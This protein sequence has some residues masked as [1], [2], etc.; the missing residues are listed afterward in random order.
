MARRLYP[1][2]GKVG[3]LVILGAAIVTS[4]VFAVNF[5]VA[6]S[7]IALG[8]AFRAG[9]RGAAFAFGHA[10]ASL[11]R[12]FA[13]RAL[14][15]EDEIAEPEAGPVIHAPKPARTEKR[16]VQPAPVEEAPRDSEDELLGRVIGDRAAHPANGHAETS[17][18]IDDL[19]RIL[20]SIELN[21]DDYREARDSAPNTPEPRISERADAKRQPAT[22]GQ[23]DFLRGTGPYIPPP[24]ELLE[25]YRGR[26]LPVDRELIVESSRQ[27]ESKLED[28]GVRGRVTNVHPG[29]II[30]MYEFEPAPGIKVNR[31]ASLEDD[32]KMVL[33]A[34]SVRIIAPIPG[35]G[36]VGIEVPNAVRETI[37]LRELIE[38][39][40]FQ[41]GESPLSVPFGKDITGNPV[42]QDLA[43]M[44]HLL[45]AGTTGAGKSVFI[46]TLITGI[47][48]KASPQDVRLILIDPKMLELSDYADIPHLLCPVCTQPKKATAI[49]RW[50]VGEME[51]RYRKLRDRGVRNIASY[52][53]K[54][55]RLRAERGRRRGAEEDDLE[56]LPYIVVIVDEL[57]DLMM[58]AQKDFESSI[59]R[60]AQMAR[61]AGIHLIL[62]TQRPSVDVVSGVIKANFPARVSFKVSSGTDS[63]T[64]IDASGAQRLLGNGDMLF[65]PP[66]TSEVVR[67]HGCW[68]SETEVQAVVENIKH[69]GASAY[70][71]AAIRAME[72]EEEAGEDGQDADLEDDPEYDRAIE[73]V[74]RERKASVSYLQRRLK[75][76]YNR[77]ARIMERM[78]REGIVGPSDGTSRPRE[79][80][81]PSRKYD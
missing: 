17:G 61:A 4:F 29:P 51:S 12:L 64:I 74:A 20:E 66:T 34:E 35:K 55:D 14:L 54:V 32:L 26:N 33:R 63:K 44:P 23:I 11:R 81:V 31:I 37:L 3:G 16:R 47:L 39:R 41:S 9:V 67:I 1:E 8:Q 71:E 62:A 53:K 27:L 10:G 2:F 46:N 40:P 45:V 24:I 18:D 58:V 42:I 69:G 7:I 21:H 60:L 50:A 68:I 28:F 77:S 70:D 19:G 57:A 49:L 36:A 65:L 75:I 78:E 73:I 59:A 80:L 15:A 76:G 56:R 79:V 48:Y 22:P 38:S 25:D 30:T 13:R 5:S 72:Q 43:K 52:N 6:R